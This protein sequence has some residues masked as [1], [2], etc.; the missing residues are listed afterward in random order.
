VAGKKKNVSNEVVE[1]DDVVE[2]YRTVS[3]AD[4]RLF[5]HVTKN[6]TD[7]EILLIATRAKLNV[8]GF[9]NKALRAVP[10]TIL[11]R[12]TVEQMNVHP[13][14]KNLLSDFYA[15][16]LKSVFVRTD[17][18]SFFSIE[19]L[20]TIS[21]S[22]KL[23]VMLLHFNRFFNENSD[24]IISNIEGGKSLLEELVERP[25]S[26]QDTDILFNTTLHSISQNWIKNNVGLYNK[27]YG[28]FSS[29]DINVLFDDFSK[30]GY[31]TTL[32]LEQPAI[33]EIL[34]SDKSRSL[35]QQ[36]L[37]EIMQL[38]IEL[39]I[40]A[41]S[42]AKKLEE[43][44]KSTESISS[45][46]EQLQ[47]EKKKL[48]EEIKSLK[49]DAKSKEREL[50]AAHSNCEKN[51]LKINKLSSELEAERA[52]VVEKLILDERVRVVGTVARPELALYMPAE[53]ITVAKTVTSLK[54][55]M[56]KVRKQTSGLLWF[57]DLEGL[58]T[59]ESF[60]VEQWMKKNQL[61]YRVVSGSTVEVIQRI[62]VDIQGD[63]QYET[64]E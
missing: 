63:M 27:S 60:E 12:Q 3:E 17:I 24:K 13:K 55:A 62:L 49:L 2:S 32:L 21:Y 1:S 47:D 31:P 8:P 15:S 4:L 22:C 19:E 33:A 26:S 64:N 11:R 14:F 20:S 58:T 42:N 25:E 6:W 37:I 52:K 46:H 23:S 53:Q 48:D 61:A 10:K 45:R 16:T 43:L 41:T 18:E 54:T 35:L 38:T 36:A 30:P 9:S 34:E 59:K 5:E 57:V 39:K 28:P 50:R 51:E 29:G 44:S 56:E 7:E 40:E